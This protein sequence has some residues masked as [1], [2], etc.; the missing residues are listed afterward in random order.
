MN[1]LSILGCGFVG[2]G[3]YHGFSPYFDIKIYDKYIKGYDTL[4][5]TVNH[6]EIL[7]ICVPTPYK[8]NYEQDLS[9]IYDVVNSIQKITSESKIV[10]I[11]STIVPGTTRKLQMNFQI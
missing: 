11:K 4:E 2:K 7:F 1:K 8:P 6:S 9:C 10:I 5:D 3:V